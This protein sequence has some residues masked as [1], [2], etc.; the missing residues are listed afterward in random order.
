MALDFA[1][2]EQEPQLAVLAALE[3]AAEAARL[4]LIAEH[5]DFFELGDQDDRTAT[6]PTAPQVAA[7]L[8]DQ[9][10]RLIHT[11]R[12]YR[13]RVLCADSSVPLSQVA[14]LNKEIMEAEHPPKRRPKRKTTT[15]M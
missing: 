7:Q 10:E 1:T 15:K 9:A 14:E 4:A 13:I 5:R 12:R 6:R 8:V 2:I 3:T 11:I